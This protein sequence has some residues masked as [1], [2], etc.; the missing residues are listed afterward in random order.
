LYRAERL[1]TAGELAA[2]AAHEI[3]NPLT[4]IRSAIQHLGSGYEDGDQRAELVGDIL[5]EV[6]RINEI[7]EGLLSFARPAE[8]K[9]EDVDLSELIRHAIAMVDTRARKQGVETRTEV[10]DD[11]SVRADPNLI[12]QVLLNVAMNALQAMPEGGAL[13]ISAGR[14]GRMVELRVGDTGPGI[15]EEDRDR[16]FDPFFTTKKDGT[17]LGLSVCYGIVQRHGGEIEVESEVERGTLVKI[18]LPD[19]HGR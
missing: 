6:D 10:P 13:D 19:R 5:A 12:T 9:F 1:A 11:L 4:S 17:G 2:G 16:L 3:R 8:P 18:R 7:V 14:L 15:S